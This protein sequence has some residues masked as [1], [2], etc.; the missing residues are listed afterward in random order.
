[1]NPYKISYGKREV[2]EGLKESKWGCYEVTIIILNVRE[3]MV[4]EFL[5]LSTH[6]SGSSSSIF[7]KDDDLVIWL[8]FISLTLESW[9]IPDL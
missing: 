4:V 3:A 7:L 8:N 2:R 1:M 5:I 6:W 9:P